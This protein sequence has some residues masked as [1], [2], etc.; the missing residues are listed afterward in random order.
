MQAAKFDCVNLDPYRIGD[1][2]SIADIQ[3][4]LREPINERN[5]ERGVVMPGWG[6]GDTGLEE[7]RHPNR[8]RLDA[9]SKDHCTASSSSRTARSKDT[10][11]T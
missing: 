4:E 3:Q 2:K 8:D 1:V 9:V 10:L 6:Y 7:Q 5:P 11:R